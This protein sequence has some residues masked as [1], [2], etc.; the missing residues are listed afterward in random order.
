MKDVIVSVGGKEIYPAVIAW[1]PQR[2]KDAFRLK[3][4]SVRRGIE[5]VRDFTPYQRN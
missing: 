5:D 1:L 2:E 4:A 3:P